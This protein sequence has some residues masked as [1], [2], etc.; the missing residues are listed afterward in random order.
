MKVFFN[1]L[2]DYNFICNKKLIEFCENTKN[3]PDEVTKLFSHILNAHAIWN[4]RILDQP[5]N[6]DVWQVHDVTLWA[7]M[8][9]QNQRTTFGILTNQEDFDILIDYQNSKGEN[10]SNTLQDILFH[11]INH[12]THHRAQ[13]NNVLKKHSLQPL[14]TDYIFYKR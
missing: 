14:V 2:F 12:S 3:L 6:I 9:Y 11:V 4:A 13:I 5:I 10:F 8:H 7:D 1:N